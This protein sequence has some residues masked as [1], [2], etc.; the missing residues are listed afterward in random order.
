MIFISH[1]HKDKPLVEQIALRLAAVFGT[2]NVFYD[3]WS[4]QPGEGIIAKM[5]EGLANCKYF[6]FFVS[7][8]SM[9]SKMVDLE[10]QNALLKATQGQA[11][12]I[13]VKIDDCMMPPI[14]LQTLYIDIF[15]NGVEVGIRQMIDVING[16]N[17]FQVG[18]QEFHNVRAFIKNEEKKLVVEIRAEYYLEPISKYL[19]L[20]ENNENE[21]NFNVKSDTMFFGGFQK[22][23]K[24]NNGKIYNGF[25][26][27]IDRGTVPGF[28]FDVEI[29]A[30]GIN[31]IQFVGVMRAINKDQ[32]KMIPVINS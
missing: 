14:L 11:K 21:L 8:N 9:Q 31:T 29:T 2:E 17:T 22:E 16:R 30:N 12:L 19:I 32:Y 26:A 25:S 20:V 5:N 28:P 4:I 24:L 3:S 10:W 13:P 23:I 18:P 15:G 1:T 6:F 27:S 7:K